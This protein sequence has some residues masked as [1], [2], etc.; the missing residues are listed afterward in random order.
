MAEV[1]ANQCAL[2]LTNDNGVYLMPAVGERNATGRIK[3]LAYD[4]GCHPDK[5]DAWYET[6][7]QLAGGTD[8]GE[9]LMLNDSCVERILSQGNE[10]WIHLLPETV[11]MHVAMVNWVCVADYR[12][13]TARMLQLAEVHYSVCV[14]QDE[15]KHWRERAINLLATACHTDCKRA[16]PADRADYLALFELLKQRVDTVNPKGALRYPAL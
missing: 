9:E 4:D 14:S 8:F 16:K 7:R 1:R 13:V 12:R 3:H 15:F 5:D 2:V 10:L 6:S 11:Y